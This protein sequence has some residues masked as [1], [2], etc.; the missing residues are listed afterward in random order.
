MS[1]VSTDSQVE[2]EIL[3]SDIERMATADEVISDGEWAD[4]DAG[5]PPPPEVAAVAA[6]GASIDH[7][8]AAPTS[9]TAHTVVVE[10]HAPPEPSAGGGP[11]TPGAATSTAALSAGPMIGARPATQQVQCTTTPAIS[12]TGTA[13]AGPKPAISTIAD[14][15]ADWPPTDGPRYVTSGLAPGDADM[16]PPRFSGD[17]GE[18]ATEWI[19]DLLDYVA[20]RNVPE[21]IAIRFLSTRTSGTARRWFDGLPTGLNFS[22]IVDKFRQRFGA[23]RG[24]CPE[25]LREFWSR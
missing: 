4:A 21:A 14:G 23:R 9:G 10:L 16:L 11:S 2:F 6:T 12:A 5:P 17:A 7:G 25:L 20:I 13:T 22:E 15:P 19:H 24:L 3:L 18:E 8:Y 1:D